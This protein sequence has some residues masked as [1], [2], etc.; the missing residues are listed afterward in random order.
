MSTHVAPHQGVAGGAGR[1]SAGPRT[2][3]LT[4]GQ[5]ALR[6]VQL[7]LL[8]AILLGSS[9]AARL[10]F[11]DPRGQKLLLGALILT[12]GVLGAHL[13]ACVALNRLVPPGDETRRTRRLV[14]SWLLEGALFPMFYLPLVLV[15]FLGPP[16]IRV[17]G[18]L[19][20]P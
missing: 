17:M 18:A 16:V 15:L 7:G 11:R 14:L 20:Q 6:A 13:L 5:V 19:T 2:A 10:L 4:G 9:D 8:G 3:W 1:G 12:A